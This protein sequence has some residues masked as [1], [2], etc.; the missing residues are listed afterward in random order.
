[1]TRRAPRGALRNTDHAAGDHEH[2][3]DDPYPKSVREDVRACYYWSAF[4][5]HRTP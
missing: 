2:E 1:V 4:G 5:F 3:G